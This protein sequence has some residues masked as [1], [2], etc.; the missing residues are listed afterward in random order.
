MQEQNA[1]SAIGGDEARGRPG[2]GGM[3]RHFGYTCLFASAVL[4]R[5]L[6]RTEHANDVGCQKLG[7][8]LPAA[9]LQGR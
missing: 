1:I 3:Q 7:L 9:L 5:I 2:W 4:L 6:H 8:R